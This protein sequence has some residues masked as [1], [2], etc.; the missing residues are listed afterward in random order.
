[1]QCHAVIQE[2]LQKR[3]AS[4]QSRLR[5]LADEESDNEWQESL[6]QHLQLW[7]RKKVF[8]DLLIG[9]DLLPSEVPADGSCALWSL[10]AMMAGCA[11][12]TA[13]TTP[14]KIEGM[15]QDRAFKPR[16]TFVK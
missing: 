12:R 15:R 4:C 2:K 5:A 3:I 1:M 8:Y 7:E 13:L 9:M 14:D 11:I 6:A 16:N 10:S